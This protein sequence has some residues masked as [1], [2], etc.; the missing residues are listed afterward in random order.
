MKMFDTNK[1]LVTASFKAFEGSRKYIIT[2]EYIKYQ[3]QDLYIIN[4]M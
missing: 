3:D 4:N 1:Y 2:L